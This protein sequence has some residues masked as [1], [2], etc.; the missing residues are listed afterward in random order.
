MTVFF[1]VIYRYPYFL[2]MWEI[3][4]SHF[5][6][7]SFFLYIQ[8]STYL[9]FLKRRPLIRWL[10]NVYPSKNFNLK[11]LLRVKYFTLPFIYSYLYLLRSP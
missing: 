8:N 10:Q 6:L 3:F 9:K 11:K 1:I 2:I 7:F 4:K 5:L